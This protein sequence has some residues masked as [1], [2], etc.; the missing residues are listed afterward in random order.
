MTMVWNTSG[1]SLNIQV[2]MQSHLSTLLEILDTLVK[3]Y[4]CIMK[5]KVY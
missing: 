3:T 1:T 5:H 4:G 2:I